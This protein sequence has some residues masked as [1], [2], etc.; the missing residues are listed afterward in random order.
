MFIPAM[1]FALKTILVTE[2]SILNQ[3]FYSCLSMIFG[4]DNLLV[5]MGGWAA[6]PGT[7]M[8]CTWCG[9]PPNLW[10]PMFIMV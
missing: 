1:T 3:V 4:A 2:A 6:A 7:S 5:A 9:E 10:V 8:C